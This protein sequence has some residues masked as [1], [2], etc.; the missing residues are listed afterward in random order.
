[1]SQTSGQERENR[2]HERESIT[3]RQQ[4]ISKKKVEATIL[5]FKKS[6]RCYINKEQ[7]KDGSNKFIYV[8]SVK[9]NKNFYQ[10]DPP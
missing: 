3:T 8:V 9:N 7:L 2:I 1:M 6:P 10:I 5:K 4:L